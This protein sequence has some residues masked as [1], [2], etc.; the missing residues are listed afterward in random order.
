MTAFETFTTGGVY[1]WHDNIALSHS[2]D[3]MDAHYGRAARLLVNWNPNAPASLIAAVVMGDA[4]YGLT[5]KDQK[6]LNFVTGTDFVMWMLLKA[7]WLLKAEAKWTMIISDLLK[8]ACD[9]GVEHEFTDT[10]WEVHRHGPG[11]HSSFILQS[12]LGMV[13]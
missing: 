4:G 3:R 10:L 13:K 5:R 9:L 8:D 12:C 11:G 6:W 7:P 1:L 2:G